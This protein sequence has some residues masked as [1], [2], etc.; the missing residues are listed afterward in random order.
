MAR[1][2]CGMDFGT[3]NST[4]AAAGGNKPPQLLPLEDGKPTIPTAIFFSFEEDRTFFGRR[5][6]SEYVTGA[7]GR[8]MR[9]IKSVLGTSL[10]KDTTRV[11]REALSFSDIVGRFVAELKHRSEATLGH[12]ID[13]IVCGRPVRFVDDD[14]AADAEA[15]AQ[16]EGAV[17]A[18]GYR[19][20]EFQFEPIAA[21]LDYEQQ[22]TGEELG[23]VADIGG[24]TSDFTVIRVSPE[25]AKARD[26]KADILATAGV[27]IGGTD[28]D[29][30]LS[31]KKVMPL[32]GYGT[33]TADG[34]RP[35][36][37]APYYDLATWHRINRLYNAKVMA[38]LHET[39]REAQ[40]PDLVSM[41][42]ALVE[43]RQG[44]RLAGRVEETKIALSAA[45]QT[46]FRFVTRDVRLETP[47]TADELDAALGNAVDSIARSIGRTLEA[48]GISSD[49]IDT[50]I[51]T[52]GSTRVPAVARVL[53]GLFPAAKAVETD[54]F[55]SVGLGLA[56]DAARRFG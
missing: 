37:S 41:L 36:P 5:A 46:D 29:R 23:L 31:L 16:L 43:D 20:V 10:F 13:Q 11:K 9:S 24:G 4:V 52:G 40:F 2:H 18:Q 44:H 47:V 35:L 34:K 26:R 32:M 39:E 21:A 27:H 19:H 22:V 45:P 42:V 38:E 3:S 17:R 12:E 33:E 50:L 56:I 25:R 55:G 8:L 53:R 48:A 51:L 1:T 28:F 7:D 15:Q 54:A 6:V 14:D 30:L 49:R